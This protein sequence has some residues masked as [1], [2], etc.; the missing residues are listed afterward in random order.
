[1]EGASHLELK[2]DPSEH[3]FSNYRCSV[4]MLMLT[5]KGLLLA[6]HALCT[7][8]PYLTGSVFALHMWSACHAK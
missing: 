6:Q 8:S 1:M 3:D 2:S 5:P 7:L 4:I